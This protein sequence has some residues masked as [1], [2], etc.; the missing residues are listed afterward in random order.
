[1]EMATELFDGHFKRKCSTVSGT[2]LQ[3][4]QISESTN[5]TLNKQL[6]TS[7]CN[8]RNLLNDISLNLLAIE[9]NSS[10]LILGKILK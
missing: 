2:K 9:A 7:V 6:L 4:A 8:L 1:M 5:P 3:Y 10:P